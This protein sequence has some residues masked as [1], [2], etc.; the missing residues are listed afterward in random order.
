MK[1]SLDHLPAKKQKQ[2]HAATE[3]ICKE[4]AVEM[5]ILFGSHA[6]WQG[7]APEAAMCCVFATAPV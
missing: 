6:R 7:D 1:T 2:L 4:A 3:V 5:V